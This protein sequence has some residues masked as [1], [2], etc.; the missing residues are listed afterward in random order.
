MKLLTTM[1]H[2]Y[3]LILYYKIK[4]INKSVALQAVTNLGL[5][6]SRRWQSLSRLHQTVLG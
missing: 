2:L 6:S 4:K 5:L 3:L 1:P